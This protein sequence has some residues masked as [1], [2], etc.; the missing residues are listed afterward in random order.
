[1]TQTIVWPLY[2]LAKVW[3]CTQAHALCML[4]ETPPIR[5]G[6]LPKRVQPNSISRKQCMCWSS[7][8]AHSSRCA[9]ITVA[10]EADAACTIPISAHRL[11]L[12]DDWEVGGRDVERAHHIRWLR[13][14]TQIP[15]SSRVSSKH[16]SVELDRSC[17][18]D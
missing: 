14:S 9:A 17:M 3:Q 11:G 7:A 2:H 10:H 18:C 12:L 15:R 6:A 1:M 16:N 5:C 13:Q 4:Y 8:N